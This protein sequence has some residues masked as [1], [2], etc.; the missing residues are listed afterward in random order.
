[1]L[2]FTLA[3]LAMVPIVSHADGGKE[4]KI[5]IN[6]S[7]GRIVV[8]LYDET[9]KTRDNFIKLVKSNFYDS[10]LFHRVIQ[11]FMIQ[12]GDPTS[13]KAQPG[14]MLGNGDIGYT[15]PAE[16]IPALIH[17]KGAL[18][19]ARQGDDINPS[20]ASS[21][22]QFYI[23]QGRVFTDAEL[24]QYE[25]NMN[26]GIKQKIFTELINHPENAA[27]KKKFIDY[28]NQNNID[29]LRAVSQKFEPEIDSVYAKVPHFQFTQEQ[30]KAYTTVGGAPHLDGNYTVFGEVVEGL[31]IVDKIA[32]VKVDG[33]SRPLED[34]RI[35]SMEIVR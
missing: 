10:T 20:K 25:L 28:Q 8:K 6:T 4:V 14:I 26:R 9:P 12:G 31:D 5:A 2:I 1:M 35:L 24:D 3:S 23:V 21:G 13:K 16:I 22:C 32:A 33:N 34:V 17:K 27:I 11:T 19:T 30:R 7:M 15:L 29:S 18:A